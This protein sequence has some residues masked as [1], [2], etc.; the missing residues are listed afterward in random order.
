MK[1]I[2]IILATFFFIHRSD[3]QDTTIQR[4][5]NLTRIWGEVADKGAEHRGKAGLVLLKLNPDNSFSAYENTDFGASILQ[6]GTWT[7]QEK[8]ITFHVTRTILKSEEKEYFMRGR[9]LGADKGEVIYTIV[10]LNDNLF[11]I[12]T[13]NSDKTLLFKQTKVVYFPTDIH[14]GQ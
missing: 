13:Q 9:I 10:E 14:P 11:I 12:K 4:F 7:L 1:Q 2:V 8:S 3:A 5:N 6:M